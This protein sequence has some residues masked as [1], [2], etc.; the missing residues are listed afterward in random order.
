MVLVTE[1]SAPLLL[2]NLSLVYHTLNLSCSRLCH[3]SICA[4]PLIA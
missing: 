3:Y 2:F 1:L 4:A